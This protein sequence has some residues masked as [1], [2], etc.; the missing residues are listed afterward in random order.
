MGSAKLYLGLQVN[1]HLVNSADLGVR[2]DS[3]MK[4]RPIS[5]PVNLHMAM[6]VILSDILTGARKLRP[7][8]ICG[9]LMDV[10]DRRRHKSVHKKCSR[11]EITRRYRAS[12]KR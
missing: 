8:G 12:K 6:W 1:H 7:C 9:E 4:F 11:R 2:L 5:R 10:T 3:D